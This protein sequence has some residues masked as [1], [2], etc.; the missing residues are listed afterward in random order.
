MDQPF[1]IE[2]TSLVSMNLCEFQPNFFDELQVWFEAFL[3]G[4][5][6][7]EI[8]AE[9]LLPS[10]VGKMVTEGRASVEVRKTNDKWFGVT[11]HEDKQLVV[12][13]IRAL[14]DQGVYPTK[15]FL[16]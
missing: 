12:D 1:P 10:V 14:V 4:L 11:Y 5:K 9:Y 6:E 8:K 7:G 16:K 13:S 2:L 3:S 15:L